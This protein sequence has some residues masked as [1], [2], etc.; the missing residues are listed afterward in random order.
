MSACNCIL[1]VIYIDAASSEQVSDAEI[2]VDINEFIVSL[3]T[4][5][6]YP[7]YWAFKNNPGLWH[8]LR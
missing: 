3:N 2:P 6:N 5:L 4:L 8:V 1:L 7:V